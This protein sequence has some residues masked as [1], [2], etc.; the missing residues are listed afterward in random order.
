MTHG[1]VRY[2][3]EDGGGLVVALSEVQLEQGDVSAGLDAAGRRAAP[4]PGFS[5]TSR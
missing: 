3:G 4:P 2:A 5:T 1:C